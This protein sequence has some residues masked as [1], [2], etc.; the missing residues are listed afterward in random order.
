MEEI[1]PLSLVNEI[2]FQSKGQRILDPCTNRKSKDAFCVC[3]IAS[4][5][6]GLE[7]SYCALGIHNVGRKL[8][9]LFRSVLF[10]LSSSISQSSYR[11]IRSRRLLVE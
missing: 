6:M 4:L 10:C 8:C 5:S 11:F 2:T 7:I 1:W 3:S 9:G